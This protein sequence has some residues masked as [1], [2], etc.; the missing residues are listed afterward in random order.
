MSDDD[1]ASTGRMR[2]KSLR[3]SR[4]LTRFLPLLNCFVAGVFI[5][6]VLICF[7]QVK[8]VS[9]FMSNEKVKILFLSVWANGYGQMGVGMG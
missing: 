4:L 3:E 6:G 9:Y 5:G 8:I 7:L 1:S 2:Q